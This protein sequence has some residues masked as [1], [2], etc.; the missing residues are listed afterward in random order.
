MAPHAVAT[1]QAPPTSAT[2]SRGDVIYQ[3]ADPTGAADST[4]AF[5]AAIA[6]GLDVEV[7]PGAYR[8]T[9]MITLQNGQHMTGRG[10]TVSVLNVSPDFNMSA[11]GVVRLAATETG[12]SIRDLG[13]S[14]HQP[15]AKLRSAMVHY[16]PA[17]YAQGAAR[18]QL[19]RVRVGG[20]WAGIDMRGAQGGAYIND[21]EMG[22]L[23]YG[24]WV[25]GALDFTHVSQFH[26]WVFGIPA[27]AITGVFPDGQ[28]ACMNIGRAD[29]FAMNN[30]ACF[31]G[32]LNVL[33]DASFVQGSNIELDSDPADLNVAGGNVQ[34]SGVYLTG[35]GAATDS[36]ISVTGGNLSVSNI[37][38]VAANANGDG[39]IHVSGGVF[40]IKGGTLFDNNAHF[41]MA[42]VAGPG[43]VLDIDAATIRPG[44]RH[45]FPIIY[46]GGAGILRLTNSRIDPATGSDEQVYEASTD[47]AGTYIAQN[48]FGQWGQVIGSNYHLGV[49]GPNKAR[50]FQWVPTIG[51]GT[52]NGS[53]APS[54]TS[55]QGYYWYEPNGIR[56][57][58]VVGFK[59]N[60]YTGASGQAF[61]SA[62]VT[63]TRSGITQSDLHVDHVDHV[64][65]DG[66]FTWL[67]GMWVS[68]G[69][70]FQL[71]EN[72]SAKAAKALSPANI[73]PST[74]IRISLSGFI[75]L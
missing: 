44:G 16:P 72:G 63:A 25:D 50:A 1:A 8:L 22:A 45:A 10:R 43:A 2:S 70:G 40:Q 74:E 38:L 11:L 21:V 20:A 19:D 68:G 69:P 53:F 6:T 15:N 36:K 62:P 3:G 39:A 26:F 54:Y 12:A 51:F 28:T 4:A 23:S 64:T 66:G 59:T 27:D 75:P 29:G 41:P 58:A 42:L 13:I 30:V 65:L 33:A 73:P 24:L 14:F 9:N 5:T 57:E 48:D 49:Y 56:F 7:P 52:G 61:I 31:E 60:A 46:Q 17:I 47:V 55:Q 35:T 18:F 67:G 34:L 32:S 71:I 37:L